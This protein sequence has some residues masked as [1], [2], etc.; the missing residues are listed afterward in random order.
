MITRDTAHP[1]SDF[2]PL[3]IAA[4]LLW[5][6]GSD[7]ASESTA[8]SP[9]LATGQ[10]A[11]IATG[12]DGDLQQGVAWP[13]PRFNDHGDGTVTDLLTG[14]MWTR[15]AHLDA[16]A[17]P[18]TW[19][20]A[21]DLVA[22][23]NA[24]SHLGHNDWRLPN[25][26]ELESLVDY[27]RFSHTLPQGHPFVNVQP[28][29]P[30][31]P[32]AEPLVSYWSSTPAFSPLSPVIPAVALTRSF[33]SG[34]TFPQSRD[35]DGGPALHVWAVRGGTG[36]VVTLPRTGWNE[37]W[38]AGDDGDAQAGVAWPAPR[39][40]PVSDGN[41]ASG[42]V[43]RDRLTGLVWAQDASLL[44]NATWDNALAA[45]QAMNA[46]SGTFGFNDWRLPNARELRSLL[47]YSQ[48]NPPLVPGHPF[49]DVQSLPYWSSTTFAGNLDLAG[50]VSME[51]ASDLRSFELKGSQFGVWAV[52]GTADSDL[53]RVGLFPAGVGFGDV[54]I[55]ATEFRV[56]TVQNTG[57]GTLQPG[58]LTIGGAHAG[59]FSI[60]MNDCAGAQ[61]GGG[62][63]C[64]ID[65][66]FTPSAPGIRRATLLL[67]SN[68]LT[69]PDPVDLIG[70]SGVLFFDGFEQG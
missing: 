2:R 35:P 27:G 69:S 32:G 20:G 33:Q 44:A 15:D 50:V 23:L 65:I 46:G 7:A 29:S 28:A 10:R 54:S 31:S 67:E 58:A 3:L 61:L 17:G 57:T 38:A 21:L 8:P 40:E 6:A 24:A 52:R 66:G 56:L 16:A 55:G 62:Q 59:D 45:I 26:N 42:N 49:L 18:R 13:D 36:G 37:S 4:V 14:L 53:V 41:G 12:D 5:G 64:A 1:C 51:L 30:V 39:F 43:V 60:G 63:S 22:Q 11:M 47:D 34:S 9:V 68:A 70:T 19:P 25:I 48:F